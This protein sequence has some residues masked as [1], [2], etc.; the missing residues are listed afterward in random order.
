[1]T[2]L[3]ITKTLSIPSST[4]SDW[5][6]NKSNRNSLYYFLSKITLEEALEIDGREILKEN[7]PIFSEKAKAVKLNKK[8][9]YTDLLWSSGDGQR[10]GVERLI[11]IYMSKPEQRNTDALVN[12]FGKKR[13]KYVVE[14]N[15]GF[16][17]KTKRIKPIALKQVE[18][19]DRV[20]YKPTSKIE[21]KINF[22]KLAKV[23]K[24]ASQKAV[25]SMYC[26]IGE[27]LILEATKIY[28]PKYPDSLVVEKKLEYAVRRAK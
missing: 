1:M 8:W 23:L 2:D 21:R 18:Y 5:K 25:D 7:T 24:N 19:S 17:D 28:A 10:I 12:L 26:R 13:V 4:L 20:F 22:Y 27:E 6:N 14:K 16:N 9:F 11:T 15:F 3:E